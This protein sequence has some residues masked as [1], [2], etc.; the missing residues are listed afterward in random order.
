M[1]IVIY[2]CRNFYSENAGAEKY[3]RDPKGYNALTKVEKGV[4][5]PAIFKMFISF[6]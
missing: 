1:K 3:L 4:A 2:I 5:L 6:K